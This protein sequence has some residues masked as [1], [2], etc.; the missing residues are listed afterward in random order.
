[1][2][3]S[4]EPKDH[5]ETE[6]SDRNLSFVV[7]LPIER[8]KVAKTLIDNRASLNLI[9]RKTFIEMDLNLKVLTP[10]HE[11]FHGVIPGQSSTPIGR[12]DLEVSCGT[13]DNKRKEM[14]IFK[15]ASFNIGYN[16]ILGRPFLLKFM[17]VIYTVY[18]TMKMPGPKGVITI[19]AN[20]H[21]ALAC[22]NVTLTHA[23]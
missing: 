13:G 23:G 8:H 10:I 4:F 15:V 22:E 18:A 2:D 11:M 16:Y 20:Q 14:L 17:A 19:K 3:I 6:L 7:K 21:D 9:M 5:P 1:V 12:I